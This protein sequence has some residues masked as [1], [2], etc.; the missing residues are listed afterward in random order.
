MSA[1][2]ARLLLAVAAALVMAG[3]DSAAKDNAPVTV[4]LG[5]VA[6]STA[7]SNQIHFATPATPTA[8]LHGRKDS[9]GDGVVD[10]QDV[11][12]SNMTREFSYSGVVISGVPAVEVAAHETSGGV[13][14][15]SWTFDL[16]RAVN[17]GVYLIRYQDGGADDFT[18]GGA[19]EPILFL[20]YDS[21]GT[22]TPGTTYSGGYSHHFDPLH[23]WKIEAVHATTPLGLS[24]ATDV[25][26]DAE[27]AI[28]RHL[29][30]SD[31]D[32]VIETED[33]FSLAPIATQ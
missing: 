31:S 16:A 18:A 23:I 14:T 5:S 30:F 4:N 25:H 27:E 6:F 12:T 24:D 22:L 26:I 10:S 29:W 33:G 3:C 8:V 21:T 28:S 17:G 19:I 32:G 13:I 2:H 1:N 20:P 9:N 15:A 7:T 11:D